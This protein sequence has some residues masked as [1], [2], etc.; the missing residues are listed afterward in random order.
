MSSTKRTTYSAAMENYKQQK[1]KATSYERRYT[2]DD[3]PVGA[4]CLNTNQHVQKSGTPLKGMTSTWMYINI[5]KELIK[6][7][8]WNKKRQNF[9]IL[10]SHILWVAADTKWSRLVAFLKTY[11]PNFWS[12][13]RKIAVFCPLLVRWYLCKLLFY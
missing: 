12:V 3:I 11:F 4:T 13:S 5:K 6:R 8:L 2:T 10:I 1:K 7:W 9:I